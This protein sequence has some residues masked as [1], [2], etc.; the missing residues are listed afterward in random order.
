[1][2]RIKPTR[3]QTTAKH[4]NLSPYSNNTVARTN[5]IDNNLKEEKKEININED[6]K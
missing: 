5:K 6:K 3:N 4:T 1:M 2:F